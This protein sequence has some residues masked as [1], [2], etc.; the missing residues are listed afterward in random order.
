MCPHFGGKS[1]GINMQSDVS[2]TILGEVGTCS[3]LVK[4]FFMEEAD[5]RS[6]LINRGKRKMNFA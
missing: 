5:F 4:K 2:R 6:F 1:V 3:L